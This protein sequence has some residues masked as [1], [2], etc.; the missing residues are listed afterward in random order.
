MSSGDHT[1]LAQVVG[2]YHDGNVIAVRNNE[3]PELLESLSRNL[4]SL[5]R[6]GFRSSLPSTD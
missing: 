4:L 2:H 6:R 5:G 3:V 1:L